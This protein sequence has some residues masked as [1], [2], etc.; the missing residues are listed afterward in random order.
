MH[1][2]RLRMLCMRQLC[3]PSLDKPHGYASLSSAVMTV[4]GPPFSFRSR[5]PGPSSSRLPG[6][7]WPPG[8]ISPPQHCRQLARSSCPELRPAAA[9]AR[10][11]CIKPASLRRRRA[12]W[13]RGV[14][15]PRWLSKAAA[16]RQ[17]C[18]FTNY[19]FICGLKINLRIMNPFG[20]GE[21]GPSDGGDGAGRG[22]GRRRICGACLGRLERPRILDCFHWFCLPCLQVRVCL[23]C[24]QVR[25][26]ARAL[27]KRR[28]LK[29]VERRQILW[30][31]AQT[32]RQRK[33]KMRYK[34]LWH[35]QTR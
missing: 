29:G 28:G 3:M 20:G 34:G 35:K 5:H 11:I 12:L 6:P 24:L 15:A 21:T 25:V 32:D 18:K 30:H 26:R 19:K 23:P 16:V 14:A 13:R 8:P 17:R 22:A 9:M 27:M 33:G 7:R 10:W 31:M 1:E 2:S 4:R